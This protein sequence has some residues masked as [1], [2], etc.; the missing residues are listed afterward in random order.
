MTSTTFIDY[1]PETP[2]VAAW[3]NDVNTGIYKLQQPFPG[4]IA[5][6]LVS[7]ETDTLHAQDFGVTGSGL[8]ETAAVLVALQASATYGKCVVFTNMRVGTNGLT[9]PAGAI[10]KMVNSAFVGLTTADVVT[11]SANVVWMDATVDCNSTSYCGIRGSSVN[12]WTLLGRVSVM[13]LAAGGGAVNGGVCLAACS[14]WEIDDLSVI[15]FRQNASAPGLYRAIDLSQSTNFR[16]RSCYGQNGDINV[17]AFAVSEGWIGHIQSQNLTDNNLYLIDNTFNLDVD[18]VHCNGN[19]EGVVC[20]VTSLVA[21]ITIGKVYAENCTVNAVSLRTGGGY[22]FGMVTTLNCDVAQELSFTPGVSDI[23]FG[24]LCLNMP[25]STT[26]RGVALVGN[27]GVTIGLLEINSNNPPTGECGRFTDCDQLTIGR[28][29]LRGNGSTAIGLRF[30]NGSAPVAAPIIK[31]G[32]VV[33]IGI[34]LPYSTTSLSS[35][36]NIFILSGGVFYGSFGML[37]A[38]E[39]ALQL[40]NSVLSLAAGNPIGSLRMK[41]NDSSSPGVKFMLQTQAAGGSGGGGQTLLTN[42]AG[43]TVAFIPASAAGNG[44]A[45][46]LPTSSAGLPS[47]SLWNNAGTPAIV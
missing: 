30:I 6:M 8:D 14:N 12:G 38:G 3:L 22:H 15:N 41:S 23:T 7:R 20:N 45:I 46:V 25:T 9:I 19:D 18:T 42:D 21:N 34:V 26:F 31:I 4:A 13:N 43:A 10:L 24:Y 47:G 17:N 33:S 36:V 37:S 39:C 27:V 1:S 2:I 32:E 35:Q 29:V 11:L 5:R 16:L 44:M 28:A 40:A